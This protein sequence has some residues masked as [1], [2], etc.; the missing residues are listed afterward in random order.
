VVRKGKKRRWQE[1]RRV[2]RFGSWR[3]MKMQV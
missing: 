3:R 2:K 1:G